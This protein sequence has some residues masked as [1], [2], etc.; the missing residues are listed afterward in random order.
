MHRYS[1]GVKIAQYYTLF[2]GTW[3]DGMNVDESFQYH[4]E[5][6]LENNL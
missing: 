3:E 2:F 6:A 4:I 5:M 1:S